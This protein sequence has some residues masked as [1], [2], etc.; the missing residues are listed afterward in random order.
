MEN[1]I[2]KIPAPGD[3]IECVFGE[4]GLFRS[5]FPQYAKRDGQV[6]LAKA[7]DYAMESGEHVFAEG[8]TGVGKSM[9]YLVPASYHAATRNKKVVVVT[10]NISLTEQLIAKDLPTLEKILPWKFKFALLKGRQNYL[11]MNKYEDIAYKKQSSIRFDDSDRWEVDAITEWAEHEIEVDGDGDRSSLEIQPKFNVWS[12]FSVNADECTGRKCAHYESCFSQKA[13][14]FAVAADIIVTNYHMLFLD[15]DLGGGILPP[16]DILIMDEAHA[17]AGIAR[18]CFGSDINENAV[19]RLANKIGGQR[20]REGQALLNSGENFFNCI[21]NYRRNGGYKTRLRSALL[22]SQ[23][24]GIPRA[25][26]HLD[27]A[28][29]DAQEHLRRE[30]GRSENGDPD[31]STR[32]SK[33]TKTLERVVRVQRDIGDLLELK[34]ENDNF[35]CAYSIDI[36][37]KNRTC[38]VKKPIDVGPILHSMLFKD[39]MKSVICTS[40]TLAIGESF[41]YAKHELG[42]AESYELVAASPFDYKKNA[43]F[44]VP[45]DIVLPNDDDFANELAESIRDV[46]RYAG[47]RTLVLFT[48]RKSMQRT[49]EHKYLKN[50]G[51]RILVQDSMQPTKLA[52]EFRKDTSSVL[53]GL[54]RFWAGLDVQGESLSVVVIEK[55]P[56]PTPDD[57]VLDSLNEDAGRKGFEKYSIPRAVIRFKQGCGRLLRSIHDR[58]C[59]VVL[60]R[61]IIEKGYGKTFIRSLPPMPISRNLE[62]IASFLKK[63]GEMADDEYMDSVFA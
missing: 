33:A 31:G 34:N 9:A 58:G 10:A 2:P 41:A 37:D 14:D 30:I 3:Y 1:G 40:A 53:F 54:E 22:D 12:E 7:I 63:P 61:R 24:F 50:T 55:L 36:D 16:Y 42:C 44:I 11:C 39:D 13:R 46:I 28:L 45:H 23:E 43:L 8:G 18:D 52:D 56:F 20:T 4:S 51:H 21:K 27:Y 60:D 47:G 17:A 59:I 35:R 15:L 49:F 26:D 38:L 32:A 6:A 19:V 48:S 29:R 62:D 5:S 57:P 25:W